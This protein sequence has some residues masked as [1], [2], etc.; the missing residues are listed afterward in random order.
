MRFPG[1]NPPPSEDVVS[2]NVGFHLEIW[3]TNANPPVDGLACVHVDISYDNPGFMTP[4]T[5]VDGPLMPINAVEPTLDPNAGTIDD[6]GGCQPAPPD[7]SLGLN[8]W[9][10][11]ERIPCTPNTQTPNTRMTFTL[12]DADSPFAGTTL[13]GHL[14]NLD[15]ADIDF[16][17]TS[18]CFNTCPE[19]LP[20]PTA[21]PF[22]TAIL[23]SIIA[24]ATV[25]RAAPVRKRSGGYAENP[26]PRGAARINV[27]PREA[28]H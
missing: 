21:E 2:A 8:E 17:T 12:A 13:I 16:L 20:V 18:V 5:P 6:V 27:D 1:L 28:L 26:L 15:P 3:A 22:A 19:I 25:I 7:D 9:I 10:L 4:E 23:T 14:N 24:L 11:V